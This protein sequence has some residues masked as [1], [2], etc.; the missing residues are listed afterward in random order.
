[1]HAM[2]KGQERTTGE[3]TKRFSKPSIIEYSSTK[4]TARKV[5]YVVMMTKKK[6]EIKRKKSVVL[7]YSLFRFLA[8][9]KCELVAVPLLSC[10]RHHRCHSHT[11]RHL[12]SL[13]FSSLSLSSVTEWKILMS[14]MSIVGFLSVN[15]STWLDLTCLVE[16]WSWSYRFSS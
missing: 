5:S 7:L 9:L 10:H 13:S 3:R 12:L 11:S 6:K 14:K 2:L 8:F 4:T 1:M 15:H 16:K